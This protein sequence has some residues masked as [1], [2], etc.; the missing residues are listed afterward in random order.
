MTVMHRCGLR[1]VWEFGNTSDGSAEHVMW[2]LGHMWDSVLALGQP[3]PRAQA[4]LKWH[5]IK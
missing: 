2:E 4:R 1:T 3:I 5:A